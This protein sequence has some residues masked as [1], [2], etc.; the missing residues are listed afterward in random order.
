MADPPARAPH[1]SADFKT[2]G[3]QPDQQA[4][5]LLRSAGSPQEAKAAVDEAAHKGGNSPPLTKDDFAR[6]HGFATFL[7]MFEA[8]QPVGGAGGQKKWLLTAKRGGKWLLWV[9]GSLSAREFLSRD[10]ALSQVTVEAGG[11]S[12]LAKLQA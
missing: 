6:Q 4:R 10:E 2:P 9:D 7:E 5:E 11:N 8:S 1:R 3:D 12:P